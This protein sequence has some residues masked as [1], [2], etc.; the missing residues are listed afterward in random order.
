MIQ[1]LLV[2]VGMIASIDQMATISD[3]GDTG[4]C[5]PPARQ[6]MNA[7]GMIIWNSRLFNSFCPIAMIGN[8]T[9]HI[10]QDHVIIEEIQGA[11]QIRNQVSICHLPNAYSTEQG[12][13]LQFQYGIRQ[14]LPHIRSYN[15]TVSPLNKDPM[16]AKFQ[17]LCD[18]ILEQESRLFQT[19][20]TELCHASKQHLSLIWQLLKLDPTLG[21][22][23][24]L[25][26]NNV[27]ASFAGQALMIWECV[28]V[29]PDQIFWDYQINIT[30][31]AYLPILV[32]N[33]TLLWSPVQ[34]M[35]SKIPQLLIVIIT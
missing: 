14:F 34:R 25:L 2:E 17:F 22:R 26:R 20:W 9:G 10:L 3:L 23:A 5:P 13:I 18:K 12:P 4:G 29:V 6:C 31:Y 19:I 35:S 32:K 1:N 11:F 24:L 30:C 33:Q 15:A 28:K 16:N 21:A 27:V 8:Y 7:G